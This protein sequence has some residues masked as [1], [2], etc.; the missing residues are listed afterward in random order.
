MNSRQLVH[1]FEVFD[2][3]VV[4]FGFADFR[5]AQIDDEFIFG[6]Q[7][8]LGSYTFFH[9]LALWL[10]YRSCPSVM[11]SGVL[12]L[13]VSS[14]AGPYA[15]FLHVAPISDM[16]ASCEI[17]ESTQPL[18]TRRS[19]WFTPDFGGFAGVLDHGV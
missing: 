15:P 7:V 10:H 16:C 6:H 18:H 5:D 9:D 2:D 12:H 13:F 19:A 3:V 8:Y 14:P 11:H 17:T 1:T 4:V